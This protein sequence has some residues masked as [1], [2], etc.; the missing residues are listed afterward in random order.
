VLAATAPLVGF[1]ALT[2]LMPE[3]RRIDLNR[4]GAAAAIASR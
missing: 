2:V 1:A 3:I 4:G